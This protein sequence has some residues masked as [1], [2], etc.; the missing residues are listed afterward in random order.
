MDL[1]LEDIGKM[2]FFK[3]IWVQGKAVVTW[4]RGHQ[5]FAA[6]FS[7]IANKCLLLPGDQNFK[8]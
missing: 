4:I 1:L 7:K 6:K 8:K 3:E 2:E 5:S